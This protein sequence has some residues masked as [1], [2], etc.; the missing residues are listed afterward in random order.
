MDT[1]PVQLIKPVVALTVS[2]LRSQLSEFAHV[3]LGMDSLHGSMDVQAS[4]AS[5]QQA[6]FDT[7]VDKGRHGQQD[8]SLRSLEGGQLQP[9]SR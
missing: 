3:Y 1:V 4:P 2:L 6:Q 9:S 8:A 7:F 5:S